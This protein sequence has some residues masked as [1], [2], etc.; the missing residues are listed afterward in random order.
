MFE[1]VVDSLDPM[2]LGSLMW[3]LRARPRGQGFSIELGEIPGHGSDLEQIATLM[4]SMLLVRIEGVRGS[5][6][7]APRLFRSEASCDLVTG[8]P[9]AQHSTEVQQPQPSSC[10]PRRLSAPRAFGRRDLAVDLLGHGDLA[11]PQDLHGHSR[12]HVQGD[13]QRNTG[14]PGVMVGFPS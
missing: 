3:S 6:P 10:L 4:V 2:T 13:Q 9:A 5:N 7:P 1:V 11:V 12:V 8:L 14:P